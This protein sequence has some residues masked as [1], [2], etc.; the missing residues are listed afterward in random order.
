MTRGTIGIRA[1]AAPLRAGLAGLLLGAGLALSPAGPGH[2][3]ETAAQADVGLLWLP[4]DPATAAPVPVVVALYDFPGVDPRGWRY[5]EQ[6]TAAGIAVLHVELQDYSADG[7]VAMPAG[8]DEAAAL[9]RVKQAIGFLAED[10]RFAQAPVGLLS[11]G[12]SGAAAMRAATD[13]IVGGRIGAMAL[14]YPGCA[15]LGAAAEAAPR[16]PVLLLHGDED[17]ANTPADCAGLAARIARTAPVR[18]LRYAGAGHAWDLPPNGPHESMTVTWPGRPGM[19]LR[20]AFW[21][22]ATEYSAAQVASFFA[23]AL[24][25]PAGATP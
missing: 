10:P 23:L 25:A 6:L 9:A 22:Q 11:F 19:R 3:V 12:A 18:H 7:I 1:K 5:A 2:A 17:P 13:P 15:G 24:P 16:A 20:T 21:A 8:D 4:D 14:L